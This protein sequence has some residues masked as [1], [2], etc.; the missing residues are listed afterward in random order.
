MVC[1]EDLQVRNMPRSAAGSAGQPGRNVRAGSGRN[2]ST[3]DQGW[4]ELRR[5]LAYKLA[6][7][8]GR[9]IAVPTQNTRRTWPACGPVSAESRRSRAAARSREPTEGS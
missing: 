9:L 6:W 2:K 4:F 8:G 5:Q 1:I 3:L 7:N